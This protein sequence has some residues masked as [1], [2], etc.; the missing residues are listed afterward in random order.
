MLEF[1]R[2]NKAT[3]SF[4]FKSDYVGRAETCP[5]AVSSLSFRCVISVV[6]GGVV[7]HFVLTVHREFG[8]LCSVV[9]MEM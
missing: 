1:F 9:R 2:I 3:K 4:L 7:K 6:T 5:F 8:R